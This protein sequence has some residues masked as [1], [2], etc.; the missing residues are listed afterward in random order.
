MGGLRVSKYTGFFLLP[1]ALLCPGRALFG[2]RAWVP[3]ITADVTACG[4]RR[5]GVP[6]FIRD[7]AQAKLLRN[8]DAWRRRT[9]GDGIQLRECGTADWSGSSAAADSSHDGRGVAGVVGGVRRAVCAGRAS[10]NCAGAAAAGAVVADSVF[11]AERAAVDG[12][13]EL[14]P[15]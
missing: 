10:V 15:A 12:G 11:A 4:K 9:A 14:Q 5:V 7:E 13:D 2:S 1:I 3:G 6:H 8:R